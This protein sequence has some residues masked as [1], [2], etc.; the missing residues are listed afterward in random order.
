ML[1]YNLCSTIMLYYNKY[2][3]R[4]AR[5]GF[6]GLAAL[7]LL[8][9]AQAAR[10]AAPEVVVSVKPLH[11]LVAA[12]M[13]DVAEPRLLLGGSASPHAYSLRPSDARALAGADHVFWIGPSLEGF[14]VRALESIAGSRSVPLEGHA[15]G[16]PEPHVWLDPVGAKDMV[17]IILRTLSAGDPEHSA[18]Y[19][20]NA[21]ALHARLDALDRE[22][23][24]LLAPV[25][26]APYIVLHDAYGP[27]ERRYGLRRVAVIAPAADRPPGARHLRALQRAI[28]AQGVRCVFGEPQFAPRF[29]R[30]VVEGTPARAAELDPLGARLAPGPEAYFRLLRQLAHALHTCLSRP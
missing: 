17:D 3:A 4:P 5:L 20:S 15:A 18:R 8:C 23:A 30:I 19:S 21:A 22:L 12:V 28:R 25:R 24:T 9:A 27:F 10:G 1:L 26:S 6:F 13:A 29:V 2:G 14:M 11:A 7:L 16:R